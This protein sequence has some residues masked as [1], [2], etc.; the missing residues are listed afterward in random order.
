MDT[1][2]TVITNV[3]AAAKAAKTAL[4]NYKL[5]HTRMDEVAFELDLIE[6]MLH[7]M[8]KHFQLRLVSKDLWWLAEDFEY[9]NQTLTKAFGEKVS[10]PAP[11][12][13]S[14]AGDPRTV[15]GGGAATAG[16]PRSHK[17]QRHDKKKEAQK[18]GKRAKN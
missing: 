1:A 16:G 15:I 6:G 17:Q 7:Q 9:I 18:T 12:Q 2:V 4:R 3:I 13:G 5:H 11:D 8:E 14:G 10:E